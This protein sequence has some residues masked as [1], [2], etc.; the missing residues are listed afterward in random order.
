MMLLVNQL[1][2]FG[3]VGV[4][5]A[6]SFDPSDLTLTAWYDPSDLSTLWQ[7]DGGT[8]P[9]ASDGDPVGRVDDKSGNANHI[10]QPS[11]GARPL[12]K[13]SGGLHWLLFDGGDGL[14]T[15]SGFTIPNPGSVY[16]AVAPDAGEEQWLALFDTDSGGSYLP[17]VQA[18]GSGASGG[19]GTPTYRVNGSATGGTT[20][21]DLL[22]AIPANTTKELTI[23]GVNTG[24][25]WGHLNMFFYSGFQL[26][27]KCYGMIILPDLSS[28]D[29]ASLETWMGAKAGLSI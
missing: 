28:G 9:V 2:G 22:T 3:I 13:T 1:T 21:Q 6:G 19:S 25:A 15:A 7:D 27:G 29:R 4:A 16:M 12:Y 20:R 18:D 10:V 23:E 14:G 17:A 24:G 5:A 8:T 11:A 26:S